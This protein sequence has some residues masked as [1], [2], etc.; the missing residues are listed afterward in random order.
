MSEENIVEEEIVEEVVESEEVAEVIEK[1]NEVQSKQKPS[2]LL[3]EDGYWT[4]QYAL[5]GGLDGGVE[6]DSLP[7]ESDRQKQM[8][9]KL[10]EDGTW[11]FDEYKYNSILEEQKK[12]S[13][14]KEI[15]KKIAELKKQL[16][17]TDYQI[18]KCYE[19]SLAGMELPYDITTLH[20]ERQ[21]IRDEINAI[22]ESM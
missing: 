12:A 22:E 16:S 11:M 3:D 13:Q 2:V 5:L 7:E 8:C 1:V 10:L 15:R 6:V 4:G 20:E 18:I 17:E 21:A 14:I 19:Y 9:Y